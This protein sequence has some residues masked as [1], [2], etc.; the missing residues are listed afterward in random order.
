MIIK[1][2]STKF[3]YHIH[4]IM[5]TKA[6]IKNREPDDITIIIYCNIINQ[7]RYVISLPSRFSINC[8]NPNKLYR[9]TACLILLVKVAFVDIC[10]LLQITVC[11][12]QQNDLFPL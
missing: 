6:Q 1:D 8:R 2:I 12:H 3:S 4:G 10:V 5:V 11:V 9:S 7:C